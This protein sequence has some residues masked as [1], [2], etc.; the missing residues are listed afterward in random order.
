MESFNKF[1]FGYYPYISLLIFIIGCITRYEYAQYGWK[2]SSSQLLSKNGLRLG[3]NLFH[4]GIILLFFGHMFGLLTPS[5]IYSKFIDPATKQSVAMIA[6]GVFGFMCFFGLSFLLH[7]RIFDDR[8]RITSSKSD[9]WVL[10]LL[11]IQ[12]ILGLLSIIV[13][14]KHPDGQSMI[15]LA[16][17]AQG[18]VTFNLNAS[19]YIFNEHFIFK[20]HIFLGLTMFLVFPFT[21]L[22]HVLSAPIN[23]LFRTGYQIVRSRG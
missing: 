7:R 12:L 23:Y 17:W 16:H 11:Y 10:V 9:L 22:V 8:I 4:V 6:G 19:D 3:N 18:I 13:S 1:I 5:I 15:A 20:L 21:R 2:S 14:A